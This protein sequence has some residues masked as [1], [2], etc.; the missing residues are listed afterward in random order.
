MNTHREVA[1]RVDPALW[2]HEVLG[3][4]PHD[5]QKTFLRASARRIHCSS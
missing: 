5:W 2:M 3:I 1:Y 4:T